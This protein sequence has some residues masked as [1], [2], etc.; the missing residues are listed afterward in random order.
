MITVTCFWWFDPQG[1]H[2]HL[3]R[4]TL[5]D[6]Q[7]LRGQVDRHLTLPH[8]FVCITDRPE[9]VEAAGIRAVPMDRTTFLPGTRFVKLMIFRPDAGE[10]IGRRI[11]MLDLDT[12]IVANIDPVVDRPEDLVLWRN[13]NFGIRYRAR[14]N[15]SIVLLTAGCRPDWWRKFDPRRSPAMLAQH[16]GGTDQAW[17]SHCASPNEAHWT[18]QDGIYGAGRLGDYNPNVAGTVLP[19]NARIVF[20]PGRRHPALASEHEKHPWLKEYR[21]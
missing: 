12:V 13:P 18:D 15:T 20:F 7:L 5:E 3:Y 4:Y 1:K 2:N 16:T 11:L 17:V 6:V 8:E 9:E 10:V 19:E 21:H 14:Y